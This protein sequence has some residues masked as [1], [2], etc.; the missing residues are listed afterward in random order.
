MERVE[1]E[2]WRENWEGGQGS[3]QE[4]RNRVRERTGER[5]QRGGGQWLGDLLT[6]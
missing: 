2:G 6:T 3:E 4:D 5:E 1:G